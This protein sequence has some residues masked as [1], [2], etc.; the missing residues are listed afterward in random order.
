[1]DTTQLTAEIGPQY[2]LRAL[3]TTARMGAPPARSAAVAWGTFPPQV[4]ASGGITYTAGELLHDWLLGQR[5][6]LNRAALAALSAANAPSLFSAE[7]NPAESGLAEGRQP[8]G[9]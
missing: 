9:P 4:A 5:S 2:D 1:M 7:A 3:A 6:G 8:A